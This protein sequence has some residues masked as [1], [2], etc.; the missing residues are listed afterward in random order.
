MARKKVELSVILPVF[1][2]GRNITA[3]LTSIERTLLVNHEVLVVYDFDEDDT[4]PSVKVLQKK[5]QNIR[6]VKNIYGRGVINA[7]KTGFVRSRG[8]VVVV[9]P[10][11]LAD[12]PDTVN[13]MY[14]KIQQGFDVVCA[15]RYGRG[16]A[17]IG[18]GIIKTAL[19][20]LAGLSTPLLL[21]IGTTDIA[22]GFKMYRKK[23]VESIRIESDG[24]WEFAMEMLIKANKLGF[25][26]S[27]VPTVWRDR[28]Q[29]KSKFKLL[30]WLPK[31]IRWY[32]VGV[33]Y[34]LNIY[35]LIF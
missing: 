15:T 28:T 21:G 35:G 10:A 4:I 23:V 1:N 16:G 34:R 17:K 24:G 13:K 33:A 25:K 6:L 26:I 3:Q 2:E 22:N 32:L 7:V 31:Y 27:E 30:K 11:D 29:G 19:S 18:G 5:Y 12:N 8:D 20:R 9:M 14:K